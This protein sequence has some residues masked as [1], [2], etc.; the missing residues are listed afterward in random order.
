GRTDD[1]RREVADGLARVGDRAEPLYCPVLFWFGA[2]A[3]ADAAGAERARGHEAEEQEAR[4]AVADLATGLEQVVARYSMKE[5]PA[6]ASAY[7]E[8]CRAEYTRAAGPPA[9]TGWATA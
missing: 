6:E 7:L 8:L 5:P 1:A 4:E 3:A 9:G 2:R